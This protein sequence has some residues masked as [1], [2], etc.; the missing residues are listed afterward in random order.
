MVI[1]SAAYKPPKSIWPASRGAAMYNAGCQGGVC[2]TMALMMGYLYEA[3]R[4]ANVDAEKA[5]KAAEEVAVFHHRLGKV[6]VDLSHL[7]RMVGINI[8]MSIG[9][10]TI[11]LRM[12]LS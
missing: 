5:R 3:L 10:L 7:R 11:V 12:H 1:D 6:E 2:T 8:A 9:I 4:S